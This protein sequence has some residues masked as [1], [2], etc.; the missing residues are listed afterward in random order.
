MWPQEKVSYKI[1]QRTAEL[2]IPQFYQEVHTYVTVGRNLRKQFEDL[3]A[4]FYIDLCENSTT[5]VP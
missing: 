5:I 1:P 3:S 2:R 4:T